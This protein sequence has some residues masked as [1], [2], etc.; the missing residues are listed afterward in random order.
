MGTCWQKLDKYFFPMD[1]QFIQ[2]TSVLFSLKKFRIIKITLCL[3]IWAAQAYN[4]T[5]IEYSISL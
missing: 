2:G 1:R 3:L 5:I 4:Q